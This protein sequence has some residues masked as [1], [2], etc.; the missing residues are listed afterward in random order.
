MLKLILGFFSKISKGQGIKFLAT[1]KTYSADE[2]GTLNLT[3]TPK[4]HISAGDVGYLITGIKNAQEVKVGDTI[5]DVNSVETEGVSLCFE[6]VK[7]MVFAGIY[8]VRH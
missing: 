8:P 5:I 7:P 2:V 1:Q 6:D 4:K 3:Q